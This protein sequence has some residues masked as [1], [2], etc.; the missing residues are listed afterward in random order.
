[1]RTVRPPVGSTAETGRKAPSLP[2]VQVALLGSSPQE[3]SQAGKQRGLTPAGGRATV[4]LS[5]GQLDFL[6]L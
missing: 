1:M 4:D 6:A 2:E 5:S 3:E